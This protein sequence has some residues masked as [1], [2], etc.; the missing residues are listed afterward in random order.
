MYF[1]FLFILFSIFYLKV[2]LLP[3]IPRISNLT[4]IWKYLQYSQNEEVLSFWFLMLIRFSSTASEQLQM[5]KEGQKFQ[6]NRMIGYN[7]EEG[8]TEMGLDLLEKFL[9]VTSDNSIPETVQF[10]SN[11][12]RQAYLQCMKYGELKQEC[13]QKILKMKKVGIDKNHL[14]MSFC[15][16]PSNQDFRSLLLNGNFN[17]ISFLFAEKLNEQHLS[18][19]GELCK[20]LKAINFLGCHNLKK[21]SLEKLFAHE[22]ILKLASINLKSSISL[23]DDSVEL[24][25]LKCGVNLRHLNLSRCQQITNESLLHI[26]KYCPNLASLDLSCCY[27]INNDGLQVVGSK[28]SVCKS[29]LKVIDLSKCF[30]ISSCKNLFFFIF[31]FSIIFYKIGGIK[32]LTEKFDE[33]LKCN[34]SSF[35][36]NNCPLIDDEA[37]VHIANNCKDTLQTLCIKECRNIRDEGICEIL[38][39][40]LKLV[41]LD[42]RECNMIGKSAIKAINENPLLLQVLL[43]SDNHFL[44]DNELEFLSKSKSSSSLE[45]LSLNSVPKLSEEG[46]LSLLNNCTSFKS[47]SLNNITPFILGKVFSVLNNSK[48][49]F[50]LSSLEL[51]DN[52]LLDEDIH[53]LSVCFPNLRSLS[54]S[55]TK[56]V[57]H[58]P[59]RDIGKKKKK[60]YL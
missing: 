27:K 56:I 51:C 57:S 24:I 16:L 14:D 5:F 46:L 54:L 60:K 8:N 10:F 12:M 2:N 45:H 25:S 34:I 1:L 50:S 13:L 41:Y 40:C 38:S 52:S 53:N 35:Y 11:D 33:N 39:K 4:Q 3:P 19:I 28:E 29:S 49:V 26:S 20:N 9:S 44:T 43:F 6:D 37:L 58:A 15:I 55:G 17:Y 23:Y 30:L 32:Y 42:V 59:Y 36:I 22:N 18:S 31:Y 48:K 21:L 47:L 7:L